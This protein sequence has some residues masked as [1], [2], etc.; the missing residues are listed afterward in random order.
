MFGH[1]HFI[2]Q[3]TPVYSSQLYLYI[4]YCVEIITI[5]KNHHITLYDTTVQYYKNMSINKD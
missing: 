2:V 5:T 4:G 1:C 3:V